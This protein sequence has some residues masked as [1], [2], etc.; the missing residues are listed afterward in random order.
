M[1]LQFNPSTRR[2]IWF[3]SDI[4]FWHQNV[5]KKEFCTRPFTTIEEMNE[6]IV[7]NWNRVVRKQDFVV[8][9]GDT[10]FCGTMEAR[11]IMDRLNGTKI[12]VT[13]NHDR[14]FLTMLNCGFSWVCEKMVMKIA[15]QEVLISHYPFREPWT[16]TLKKAILGKK[17]TRYMER[18][19]INRGNWLIHGHTHSKQQLKGKMIHVG[20]DAWNYTPVSISVIQ[21]IIETGKLPNENAND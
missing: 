18:R 7:R 19:P 20:V 13:G 1:T 15:D 11:T 17:R 2:N 8:V 9:V 3:T 12:L 5:L 6:A 10:F 4:H 21:K 14:N 16:R